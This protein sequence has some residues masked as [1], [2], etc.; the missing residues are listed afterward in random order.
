MGRCGERCLFSAHYFVMSVKLVIFANTTT[1][2]VY[3]EEILIIL[4]LILFNGIFAMSEIAIISARKIKLSSLAKKGSKGAKVA[5]KLANDPD[6][7]LSTI[8]IGITLIGILTGIYSGAALSGKFA[9]LL[10]EVGVPASL[11]QPVAQTVIVIIVTMLSIIFGELVPKRIG[12]SVAE[13]ASTAI[14]RPMALLS[15]VA[16]PFVW[17]LAKSTEGIISLLGIKDAESKIT[18]EDIKSIV[19][20]G[21]NS[22]AVQE[23]EQD[24]VERVFLMGDL[25]VSSLM[26]HRSDLVVLDTRM[27]AEE[28][29]KSLQEHLYEAYP[30]I[31]RK[32]DNI[33]GVVALKDLIFHLND[34]PICLNDFKRP[35]VY[36]YENMSVY[37]ALEQMR[38]KQ[39]SQALICDEFGRL[40][41]II[42]LRDILEGL[43]G[44]IE[45]PTVE[46]DIVKRKDAEGWL[47]DG[48]CSFYDF[49]TYFEREDLYDHKQSYS[50]L[51]GLIIE[52]LSHIPHAGER[53]EWNGFSMEI[54][55]MDGARVDK[56]LVKLI[57][58]KEEE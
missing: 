26:T 39:T 5:L 25:K 23:V 53:V 36:F 51:A 42:T 8:Q 18:E 45:R 49:L 2:R 21:K 48:Q 20:E 12:M 24:I 32:L 41:G 10:V 47:V 22:G 58:P 4:L 33:L 31:D 1:P 16:A 56:V 7:F 50:T 27:T 3:M 15:R 6:R 17:I 30:L 14:A 13:R 38:E 19:Q 46:P 40:M 35:A 29:R 54:V 44:T 52:L 57:V 9:V 28:I 11:A 43:V 37:R 55:D 34:D